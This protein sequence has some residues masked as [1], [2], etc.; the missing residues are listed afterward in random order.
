LNGALQKFSTEPRP[1]TQGYG[2]CFSSISVTGDGKRLYFLKQSSQ[3]GIY[4]ADLGERATRIS[5]PRHLSST[6]DREFPV[7]W[8]ADS[9]DIVFVSR[10]EHKWGFYRQSLG[11]ETATPILAEIATTGLGAVFPRVS[12]DGAWLVYAPYPADYVDGATIDVFRVAITGGLPQRV[13]KAAI[14]DTPRCSRAPA[15]PCAIAAKD[16]DL[17]TFTAFDP[18]QGRG[19]ELGRFKVDEPEKFY[20]WDLSPE[21]TRIAILKRGGSEIHILDLGTHED[22]RIVVKG[23]SGLAALDWTPD[24][25]GLFT[26]SRAA[27]SVL[28][29]TDLEGHAHVLWEPKG[30]VMIW[31]VSSPDGQHV[32]LPGFMLSSNVWSMEDF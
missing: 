5:P 29:E 22:R 28:L 4:V 1:L 21:G 25:R 13:M 8:T 3:F 7:A 15:T 12:P 19:R 17:L 32:A 31:A 2:A 16:K 20:T 6:D 26:S 11:S 9:R 27:G 10:R 14:Y 30:D 18:V 24:G 23:W